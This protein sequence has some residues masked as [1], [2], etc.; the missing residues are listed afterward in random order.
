[1]TEGSYWGTAVSA[2][3]SDLAVA[4]GAVTGTLKYLGSGQL[5]TDW[6]AGNFMALKFGDGT[7][8]AVTR[9]GLTPSVSSGLVALDEDRDAVMKVTDKDNQKLTVE[10][11]Y[12]GQTF[13]Q[14]Y[15]LSGLTLNSA[16]A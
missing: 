16:G 3:Q 12:N 9:V 2:M 8:G 1:M 4:N 10:T 15:D 7:E 5:V 14:Y 11:T 6:G 13:T